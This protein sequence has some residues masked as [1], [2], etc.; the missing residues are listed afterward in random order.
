MAARGPVDGARASGEASEAL[1]LRL[2]VGR[3]GIGVE[4]CRPVPLFGLEVEEL[5]VTPLGVAFPI[6]LSLGVK[7]FRGRRCQL[8]RLVV[9]L[10]LPEL[11]QAWA[12]RFDDLLGEPVLGVRL[13]P[14]AVPSEST[15][16]TSE[17]LEGVSFCFFGERSAL[18]FELVLGAG[19]APRVVVDGARGIGLE[20][21]ALAVALAAIDRWVQALS[22]APV[23]GAESAAT[24]RR[25]R[26]IELGQIARLVSLELL[27]SLGFRAPE[28]GRHLVEAARFE[29]GDVLLS[30]DSE[31]ARPSVSHRGL[32]LT[33]LAELTERADTALGAGDFDAAR[34]AYLEALELA[35]GH[36]D[37]LLGIAEI[38]RAAG[39]RREA[40]RAILDELPEAP[41]ERTL[42]AR[43]RAVR[44]A[45]LEAE[46]VAA[47]ALADERLGVA[48]EEE[49]EVV[50]AALLACARAERL[51]LGERGAL[52]DA[53]ARLVPSLE[54]PRFLRMEVNLALGR[55]DRVEADAL[56][57][58]SGRSEA[59]AR[60]EVAHAVAVGFVG[61]GAGD[62]ATTW[63]HKALALRPDDLGIK[64]ELGLCLGDLGQ[65]LRSA[66]V[67][68]DALASRVPTDAEGT[69]GGAGAGE[70]PPPLLD[71]AR[72]RLA[73]ISGFLL[74]DLP[75][76]H[77]H[78]RSVESR[79]VHALE[80]RRLEAELA[81]KMGDEGLRRRAVGRLLEAVELGWIRPAE[82][83]ELLTDL[84]RVERAHGSDEL[85][86]Q[87]E[88]LADYETARA[89]ARASSADGATEG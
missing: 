46:I 86:S 43:T 68:T 15:Q 4:L 22:G 14:R 84:A 11:G 72:L 89:A 35:P 83:A 31:V 49:V 45:L 74:G 52:L 28:V 78:A 47:P 36:P 42:E 37:I 48:A 8:R 41:R 75:L 73:R 38:D 21:P 62:R 12:S 87:A 25:G 54:R 27:P 44:R 61:A 1:P 77:S 88:R 40:I 82:R 33:G 85:A 17:A 3:G 80:A 57:L 23:G 2:S 81:E 10:R 7:Q 70:V 66:E 76:A 65:A 26:T 55:L 53:A 6:D 16:D 5:E 67:L 69:R 58:F 18:A 13:T 34:T 20:R 30:I 51:P 19:P 63:F 32:R 71:Q 50:F 56:S 24:K 29:R 39:G 64:V 79:S 60:A 9:R 59:G